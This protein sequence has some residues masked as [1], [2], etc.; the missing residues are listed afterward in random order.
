MVD[1]GD[2]ERALVLFDA[3]GCG[4]LELAIYRCINNIRAVKLLIFAYWPY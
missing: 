2:I 1:H 3:S 4:V